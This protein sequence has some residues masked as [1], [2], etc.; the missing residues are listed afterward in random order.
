MVA[1]SMLKDL[2]G[3]DDQHISLLYVLHT[4]GCKKE[5][6]QH[7]RLLIGRTHGTAMPLLYTPRLV[8]MIVMCI[9]F[10]IIARPYFSLRHD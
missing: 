4:G 8:R 3:M 5:S 7:L 9:V 1:A 10:R 2:G 6:A